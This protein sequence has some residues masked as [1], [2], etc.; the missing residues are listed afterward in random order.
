DVSP[1]GAHPA[2]THFASMVYAPI[3]GVVMLFGDRAPNG[4]GAPSTWLWDGF[5][6]T[7]TSSAGAPPFRAGP[8]IAYDE[9]RGRVVMFG[10]DPGTG[11]PL[12]DTW[13]W[14][15][16]HWTEVRVTGPMPSAR[17]SA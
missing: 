10:G 16:A 11:A 6:W 17:S 8:A 7:K 12:G 13:E 4:T 3:R 15:G 2:A 9:G 14:D 1:T 5:S